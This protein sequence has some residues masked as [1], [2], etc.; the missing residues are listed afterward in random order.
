MGANPKATIDG[1]SAWDVAWDNYNQQALDV[2]KEHGMQPKGWEKRFVEPPPKEE[3]KPAP[4]PQAAPAAPAAGAL[5]GIDAKALEGLDLGGVDP[6]QA[7]AGLQ[8]LAALMQKQQAE[9]GQQ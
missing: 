7:M 9:Q 2:F 5:G 8:A 6:Q 4:P 1:R 3:E